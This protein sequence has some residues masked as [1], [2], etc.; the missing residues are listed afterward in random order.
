M[1]SP[2]SDAGTAEQHPRDR[3]AVI[4]TTGRMLRAVDLGDW[5]EAHTGGCNKL[6]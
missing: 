5:D 6:K 3:T 1:S 4:E 2:D